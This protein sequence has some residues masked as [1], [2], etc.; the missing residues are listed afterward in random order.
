MAVLTTCEGTTIQGI[1]AWGAHCASGYRKFLVQLGQ[2]T[3]LGRGSLRR[4]WVRELRK[5]GSLFDVQLKGT[6][7]RL[8]IGDNRS[9]IKALV[10]GDAFMQAERMAIHRAKQAGQPL[11]IIDIGANAGLFSAIA[12]HEAGDDTRLLAIEPNPR[13]RRRL[14]TNIEFNQRDAQ[15]EIL[16]CALGRARGEMS[17]LVDNNDLG[18]GGLAAHRAHKMHGTHLTVP[19]RPLAE[20]VEAASFHRIDVLKIDVEGAEDQILMPFLET[21]DPTFWPQQILIEIAHRTVWQSDLLEAL[22]THGYALTEQS[23]ADAT[24]MRRTV[25]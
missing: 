23:G 5:T 16:P 3:P 20:I 13:L 21:V 6:R 19:V 22:Y 14:E 12:L 18:G 4:V 9:E 1:E 11:Y 8:E 17:F 25:P 2:L 10:Q 24:L 15:V 7:V